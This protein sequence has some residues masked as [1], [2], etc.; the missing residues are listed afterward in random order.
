MLSN[1]INYGLKNADWYRV[2]KAALQWVPSPKIVQS[3]PLFHNPIETTIG[4]HRVP[5]GGTE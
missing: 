5:A 4:D 2:Q 3:V 1:L